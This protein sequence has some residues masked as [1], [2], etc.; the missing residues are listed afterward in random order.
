MGVTVA[1]IVER[2]LVAVVERE[3]AAYNAGAN[4]LLKGATRPAR[5][6]NLSNDP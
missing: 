4:E 5:V 2:K 6:S 3:R 1:D